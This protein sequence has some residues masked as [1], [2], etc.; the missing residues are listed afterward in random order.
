LKREE[1]KVNEQGEETITSE[2]KK[3][4]KEKSKSNVFSTPINILNSY[5]QS[6]KSLPK[7]LIEMYKSN[8]NNVN[9]IIIFAEFIKEFISIILHK[10]HLENTIENMY[11]LYSKMLDQYYVQ[12][13]E[14]E[15]N[16]DNFDQL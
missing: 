13:E 7:I 15:V 9:N 2:N 4:K 3:M 11:E 12:G 1:I 8:S 16:I 5:P 10:F 14:Q 6:L